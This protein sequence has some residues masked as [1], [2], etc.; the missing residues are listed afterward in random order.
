MKPHYIYLTSIAS[1]LLLIG[2][3]SATA[4]PPSPETS[5][6][7]DIVN[8]Q[9]SVVYVIPI[10]DMIERG[11]VHFLRRALEQAEQDGADVIIFDMDT[12]GGRL[13]ATE[14]IIN[15]I[16]DISAETYTFVNPNAISAGAITAMATDHIYMAPNGRIG[17]AMP[18][19]ISPLPFGGPQEMPEGLKEKAI[20]PTVALIRSAA[21]RKGHD[22]ELAEAMVRPEFE[23]KIGDKIICPKDQL[24]TLTS[25]DA[26]QLVGEDNHP[27]LSSGTV[28]NI[29]E[30]LE[31]IGKSDS[32]VVTV[33]ITVAEK[34]SRIIDGFPLSQILLGLGLLALYTEFKSPGFGIPGITGIVLL[35]IWF[36]GHNVA[37]L[38]GMGEI[39]LF[40]LGVILLFVEM[41]VIPGFG[42]VGITGMTLIIVSLFMGMVQH[43]PGM[44][45]YQPPEMDVQKAIIVLGSSLFF[46]FV[47]AIVLARFLPGTHVF[48]RIM[49]AT[50]ESADDGYLASARTDELAGLQGTAETPLHP[51]GIG[52]FGDKRLNVVTRGEFIEKEAMIVI[53]ETHGNRIVVETVDKI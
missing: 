53:A 20:S 13:D 44:P 9:S 25:Q 31:R 33:T 47:G 8:A 28:K 32:R 34:I 41:F 43:Y 6:E 49:L 24:L 40:A 14:E 4:G 18:I 38:A 3:S 15:M 1:V 27:L 17:D 12:P 10:K 39:V 22:P 37:G 2:V 26:E 42:V 19:M 29:E 23:Y 52:V 48:Q 35:A 51:A 45:W 46:A 36:W 7:S 30:L 50:S 11:L 16:T 21:Q 5:D